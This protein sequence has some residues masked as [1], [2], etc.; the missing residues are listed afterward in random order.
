MDC[1]RRRFN[2]RRLEAWLHNEDVGKYEVDGDFMISIKKNVY[3]STIFFD[4]NCEFFYAL[5]HM[6]TEYIHKKIRAKS[7]SSK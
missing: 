7:A 2:C 6:V 4:D 3:S 1:F 5:S